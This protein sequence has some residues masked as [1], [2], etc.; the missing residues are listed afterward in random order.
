VRH[1]LRS[2]VEDRAAVAPRAG[3]EYRALPVAGAD[4]GVPRAGRAVNEVPGPQLA[5]LPLDHKQAGARHVNAYNADIASP[6]AVQ[7]FWDKH[8]ELPGIAKPRGKLK[9]PD[10][11]ASRRQSPAPT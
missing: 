10:V 1:G 2:R 7:E 8:G 5:L 6:V 4:E 11:C 9:A 3:H